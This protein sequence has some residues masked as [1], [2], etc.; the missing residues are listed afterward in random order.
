MAVHDVVEVAR[1]ASLGQSAQLLSEQLGDR[2]A[3]HSPDRQ[4]LVAV[5]VADR[6]QVRWLGGTSSEVMSN[7]T[8]GSTPRVGFG[9]R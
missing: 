5:L 9:P 6:A 1:A 4:G 8:L 7:L 3:G 2:V